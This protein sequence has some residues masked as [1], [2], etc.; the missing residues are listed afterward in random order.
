MSLTE[1]RIGY[2]NK[3]TSRTSTGSAVLKLGSVM[4]IPLDLNTTGL[5]GKTA[6]T[7]D[8]TISQYLMANNTYCTYRVLFLQRLA[9]PTRPWNP[10]P[11]EPN[12]NAK[13]P[14]NPYRTIDSLPVDLTTF[15]G[16]DGKYVPD[17][18]SG[19][20]AL[21][22]NSETDGHVYSPV[23]Q[24]SKYTLDDKLPILSRERGEWAGGRKS[25]P[26]VNNLW[27]H[28]LEAADLPYHTISGLGT[29]T[30]TYSYVT[31]PKPPTTTL[32][33]KRDF[34]CTLGM[35]NDA[36]WIKPSTITLPGERPQVSPIYAYFGAPNRPFPWLTW[37]NRPFIS[38][39]ELLLVPSS[40]PSQLLF[41]YRMSGASTEPYKRMEDG[42]LFA[43]TLPF[44][45][46]LGLMQSSGVGDTTNA[47]AQLFRLLDF[48]DV[49]SRFAGT[50]TQVDPARATNSTNIPGGDNG[51]ITS[52]DES[53][54]TI[55]ERNKL[56]KHHFHPPFNWISNY[57]E[58]GKINL[59]T[60]FSPNVWNG[61]MN[62]FPDQLGYFNAST[63]DATWDTVD[64]NGN[65]FI[66]SGSTY[67]MWQRFL[68]SRR[69]YGAWGAA[70]APTDE[71]SY[72]LTIRTVPDPT[73]SNA[74]IAYPTRFE[75]PFRSFAGA[76]LVPPLP[77]TSADLLR[78]NIAN[79]I[80][81]TLLRP[82]PSKLTVPLF[83]VNETNHFKSTKGTGLSDDSDVNHPMNATRN[84][85]FQYQGIQRLK[86]LTTTNSNVYAVWIT[87]GYFEV[88]PYSESIM[89]DNSSGTFFGSGGGHY[90]PYDQWK[91]FHPDDLELG[92][93]L[94]LDTGE[95][96][97][98]RAFYLIDR[99][100]PAAFMRG[101]DFNY[102]KTILLERLIQ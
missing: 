1:P 39:M 60:M 14:V 24:N 64:Q 93:E 72:L 51:D 12:Y 54:P 88:F 83:S 70:G 10:Y 102:E 91:K 34:R 46:L 52:F 99:S 40:S 28:N 22:L 77:T 50:A 13:F 41:N 6:D 71:L 62:H 38:A 16:V 81:A 61:L 48:V 79:E 87:I 9:D 78:A 67:S 21:T 11:G 85:Y 25:P 56:F 66:P 101:Q 44:T 84:P 97:R 31:P 57:R 7:N 75:N 36:F 2:P 30:P 17:V 5:L 20:P 86:N 27:A 95:V 69:G 82:D 15:N 8:P 29:G 37:N 90:V 18:A 19:K 65:R 100:L 89:S 55:A 23:G 96:K 63:A 80:N 76:H 35:L 49:P 43:T 68:A 3:G 74:Q 58:P 73:A 59:N 92:A 53:K 4:D 45:H 94:G 47:A 33:P 98:N 26:E 42:N 32:Y